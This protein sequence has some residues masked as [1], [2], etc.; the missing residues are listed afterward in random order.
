M[1]HGPNAGDEIRWRDVFQQIRFGASHECALDII[2][3][4]ERREHD[5]HGIRVLSTDLFHDLGA[6][7]GRHPEVDE[8]DVRSLTSIER[9]R[10][11]AIGRLSDD[12]DLW[13]FVQKP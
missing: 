1:V 11:L 8:R 2:V 10:R 7:Q 13:L 9:D 4:V 6:V 5:E 12:F 3:R